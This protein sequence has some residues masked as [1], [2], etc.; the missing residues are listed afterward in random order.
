MLEIGKSKLE[1]LT[2]EFKAQG[3][4]RKPVMLVLAE[5]TEVADLVGEHFNTLADSCSDLQL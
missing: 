4:N 5:E 3:I 1:Q 2:E